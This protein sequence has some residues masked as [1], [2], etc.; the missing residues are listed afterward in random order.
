MIKKLIFSQ[1]P[2]LSIYA[3]GFGFICPG[4]E[5]H[6]LSL[7]EVTEILF[8]LLTARKNY[9]NHSSLFGEDMSPLLTLLET[10]NMDNMGCFLGRKVMKTLFLKDTL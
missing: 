2:D 9:I 10:T 1:T 7:M 8:L 5:S 6:H 3:D 4:L